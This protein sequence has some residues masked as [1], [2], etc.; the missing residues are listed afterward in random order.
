M[1]KIISITI[2]YCFLC[3]INCLAEKNIRRVAT[4]N[5]KWLGTNSGNQ[6]DAVEN[7]EHYAQQI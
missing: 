5:M 2:L 7:L 3:T 1:I 6:L 4:W